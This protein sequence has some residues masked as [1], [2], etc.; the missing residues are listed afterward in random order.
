MFEKLKSTSEFNRNVLI[1]MIGTATAQ[2][3]PIIISPLL[4]RIYTPS[5][6]GIFALYISVISVLAVISTG[7]YELAIML[8]KENADAANLMALS[9]II[10]ISFSFLLLLFLYISSFFGISRY[11]YGWYYLVPLSVFFIGIYQNL[12]FWVNRNKEYKRQAVAKVVQNTSIALMSIVIGV[13]GFDNGLILGLVIGQGIVVLF[14]LFFI[15]KYDE[16]NMRSITKKKICYL[17]RKYSNFPKFDISASLA[18]VSSQQVI[19][20]LFN[21]LFSS[22][23][24]GYFYMTQRMLGAPVTFLAT[25]ILDVFKQVA[26]K[27]YN[28]FGNAKTIYIST[29]KKLLALSIIPTIF[30]Y[31]YS[32]EV[33]VF[34]FGE[35][36]MMA[37]VYAQILSP[38]LFFRFIANPLSYMLYIG[39]RQDV[40]LY[41]QVSLFFLVLSAFKFSDSAIGIVNFLSVAFSLFYILNI[42]ISAKIAGAFS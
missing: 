6:F 39:N 34:V 32:V 21:A 10:V 27:E 25:S 33:F 28:E 36:W 2:A 7:R 26:S 24:A 8:P 11:I 22:A 29:F 16:I 18:S 37:G 31:V 40:N 42:I 9:T 15:C 14:L 19:N 41:M 30:I 35:N 4:T 13:M 23:V 38:M 12:N 3:V 5:E 17:A 1:L 20:I